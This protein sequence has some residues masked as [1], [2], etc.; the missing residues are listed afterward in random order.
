MRCQREAVSL[1]SRLIPLGDTAHKYAIDAGLIDWIKESQVPGYDSLF[2][3]V[4]DMNRNE[5]IDQHMYELL[6]AL[7]GRG[8]SARDSL[9]ELGLLRNTRGGA[10]ATGRP[11]E[12]GEGLMEVAVAVE[13]AREA[14]EAEDQDE[15]M[16]GAVVVPLPDPMVDENSLDV[17]IATMM[18]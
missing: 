2:A 12:P 8:P 11:Y 13:E 16:R 4:F 5:P 6:N 10:S 17:W 18:D 1:L 3:A 15:Q 14:T 9:V 7:C